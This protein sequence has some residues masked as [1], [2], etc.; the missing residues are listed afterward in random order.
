MTRF[1]LR[2]VILTL[3]IISCKSHKEKISVSSTA[4][5]TIDSA[6]IHSETTGA[7]QPILADN[8]AF[9]WL[10]EYAGKTTNAVIW[11][12]R[13]ADFLASVVPAAQLDL[14]AA[15][16]GEKISL[17][18]TVLEFIGGPPDDVKITP[19]GI[20]ILSACRFHSCPEKAWIWY[21]S[22]NETVIGAL[23]HYVFEG[24]YSEKPSLLVFS[25]Q[26]DKSNIP[27]QFTKDL[28]GWLK[29]QDLPVKTKRFAGKDGAVKKF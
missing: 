8:A 12:D 17:K 9:G 10:Q 16:H 3:L 23:V 2:S 22:Y 25:L 28:N 26:V 20:A 1:F 19:S 14:G 5:S 6:T 7:P 29:S 21:D 24:D 13:F 15:K 18:S 4:D 11:D 27:K